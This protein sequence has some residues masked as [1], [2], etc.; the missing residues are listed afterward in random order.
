MIYQGVPEVHRGFWNGVTVEHLY[1]LYQAMVTNPARVLETTEEPE[2]TNANEEHVFH[3]LQQFIGNMSTEDSQRFLLFVTGSSVAVSKTITVE[4]N[5]LADFAQRPISHTCGQVLK[6][7][8]TYNSYVEFATQ[9]KMILAEDT[10]TW[11]MD[12]L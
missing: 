10:Y 4:F 12:L 1:F 5:N 2:F 11:L 8:Q 3:Y 7:P 9:F 6:L